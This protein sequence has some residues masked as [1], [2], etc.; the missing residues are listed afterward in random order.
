MTSLFETEAFKQTL[1]VSLDSQFFIDALETALTQDE[2]IFD[3]KEVED[4]FKLMCS[5][6]YFYYKGKEVISGDDLIKDEV[7]TNFLNHT[8]RSHPG[9]HTVQNPDSRRSVSQSDTI[10]IAT[11]LYNIVRDA[12]VGDTVLPVHKGLQALIESANIKTAEELIKVCSLITQAVGPVKGKLGVLD[13]MAFLSVDDAKDNLGR[14]VTK[15]KISVTTPVLF[16]RLIQYQFDMTAAS[17]GGKGPITFEVMKSGH[18][19]MVAMTLDTATIT[20]KVDKGLTSVDGDVGAFFSMWNAHLKSEEMDYVEVSGALK[21]MC[22]T[23]LVVYDLKY[24]HKSKTWTMTR[25][26]DVTRQGSFAK[27]TADEW[28]IVAQFNGA[29]VE[30]LNKMGNP[31]AHYFDQYNA[32]L[33]ACNDVLIENVDFVGMLD[34]IASYA[35][36]AS[37]SYISKASVDYKGIVGGAIGFK[38]AIKLA[39]DARNER[40]KYRNIGPRE[41]LTKNLCD[42]LYPMY[43]APFVTAR[44]FLSIMVVNPELYASDADVYGCA[45]MH[46][47]GAVGTQHD[48]ITTKNGPVMVGKRHYY[49]VNPNFTGNTVGVNVESG[50]LYTITE[51]VGVGRGLIDDVHLPYQK[52]IKEIIGD[53]SV[54]YP[55]GCMSHKVRM[56][57]KGKYEHACLK[58]VLNRMKAV[59]LDAELGGT[60]LYPLS[61]Y[62]TVV[63]DTPGKFQSGEFFI[64]VSGRLDVPKPGKLVQLKMQWRLFCQR[65]CAV[66]VLAHGVMN[67]ATMSVGKLMSRRATL[68]DIRSIRSALPES[69]RKSDER[70]TIINGLNTFVANKGVIDEARFLYKPYLSVGR[71]YVPPSDEDKNTL[72]M[73]MSS[74]ITQ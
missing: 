57:H 50:D 35:F 26:P 45:R 62:K 6:N 49:D 71:A 1:G 9:V 16:S 44:K 69:L 64:Y 43:P 10:S 58:M 38:D 55:A 15:S 67:A 7:L 52:E 20:F 3:M 41:A 48:H 37:S 19:M 63:F 36:M 29:I 13:N 2:S 33:L 54:T 74:F 24:N 30:R 40:S 23:L 47:Y 73:D 21:T 56:L 17:S 72:T 61:F 51:G 5:G 11:N 27:V 22:D 59:D 66:L 46:F 42:P 25:H 28:A 8:R 53:I 60:W 65:K 18:D 32:Y 31:P 4:A 14:T 34:R 68:F 70:S 39:N 12:H